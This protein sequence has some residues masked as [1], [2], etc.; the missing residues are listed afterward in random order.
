MNKIL[1]RR[2]PSNFNQL[3][4]NSLAL[5]LV[6]WGA[7]SLF[8]L[9]AA[10]E[11][12][13]PPLTAPVMDEANLLP[14]KEREALNGFLKTISQ[15]VQ[16]QIWIVKELNGEPIE[17]LGTRAANNWALGSEQ[18]D[19]GV[20]LLIAVKERQTRFDVGTGLSGAI[21]DVT[22]GRI[23]DHIIRPAFQSGNFY[24]GLRQASVEIFQL[25]GG[26]VGN[27]EEYLPVSSDP[28]WVIWLI[29]V[30]FLLMFFLLPFFGALSGFR[31]GRG[32]WTSYSSGST[33]GRGSSWGGGGGSSW[34]GGGGWSGGGGRF[35][36]G[37]A[38]GGW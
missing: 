20:L 8:A 9:H 14:A 2:Q 10:V 28:K 16:F 25:A 36:G 24:E 1:R 35:G 34:G 26:R 38:T 31:R 21:P 19:N 13:I 6:F 32:G 7:Q 22:A 30:A 15:T 37:G 33:W 27:S 23:I 11:R 17:R 3:S 5:A 4:F 18:T 12:A 29:V